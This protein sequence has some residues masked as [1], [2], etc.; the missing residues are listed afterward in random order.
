M[1][2]AKPKQ[3]KEI[4]GFF[5]LSNLCQDGV[6]GSTFI[7]PSETNKKLNSSSRN[8]PDS[9]AGRGNLAGASGSP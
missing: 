2:R 1:P 9:A 6:I 3:K 4:V 8:C 7:L 5:P